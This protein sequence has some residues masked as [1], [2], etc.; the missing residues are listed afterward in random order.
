[1]NSPS[2]PT[3]AL[4]S[5][6][7]LIGWTLLIGGLCLSLFAGSISG[8]DSLALSLKEYGFPS[9]T[10]C[11][12]G[13]LSLAIGSTKRG[14]LQEVTPASSSSETRPKVKDTSSEKSNLRE[15]EYRLIAELD[16]RHEDLRSELH[17]VSTLIEASLESAPL[18]NRELPMAAGAELLSERLFAAP[19]SRPTLSAKPVDEIEI[20]VE[21]EELEPDESRLWSHDKDDLRTGELEDRLYGDVLAG[22]DGFVWDF[23]LNRQRDLHNEDSEQDETYRAKDEPQIDD[24]PTIDRRNISWFDWDEDDLA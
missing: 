20:T 10:L 7:R 6:L 21:L 18:E 3:N 4:E 13:I 5:A 9:G 12:A 14:Q 22:E 11:V 1:V 15:L 2:A 8:V 23:P 24:E 19:R 16:R 17:E